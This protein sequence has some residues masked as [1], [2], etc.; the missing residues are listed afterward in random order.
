[1]A[2]ISALNELATKLA[3]ISS[4]VGNAWVVRQYFEMA[5]EVFYIVVAF[6]A[7]RYAYRV[8]RAVVTEY[9]I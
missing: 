6:I 1:M 7:I 4:S 3:S 9:T 2:E 5:K 8:L